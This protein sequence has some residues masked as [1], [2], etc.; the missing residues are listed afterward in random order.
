MTVKDVPLELLLLQHKREKER[1]RDREK[2]SVGTHM[3]LL[4]YLFMV[5]K[6]I[7]VHIL[8]FKTQISLYPTDY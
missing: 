6:L 8:A 2:M 4:P 7:C 5:A 1:Q 3:Q